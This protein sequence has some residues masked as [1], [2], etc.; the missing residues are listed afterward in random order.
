MRRRFPANKRVPHESHRRAHRIRE[1]HQRQKR[2]G[3]TSTKKHS[4]T[5]KLTHTNLSDPRI[6]PPGRNEAP[7]GP[8]AP[9]TRFPAAATRA[10][11]RHD[12]QIP[13]QNRSAHPN[14]Q[15][16]TASLFHFN[17]RSLSDH[18]TRIDPGN[19]RR[20]RPVSDYPWAD[21]HPLEFAFALRFGCL[22]NNKCW[23]I[24]NAYM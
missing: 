2:K 10:G 21:A 11:L 7:P 6:P 24:L 15:S 17:F 3:T 18:L 5:L 4:K 12:P 22:Y 19:R 9:R 1:E 13:G 14:C 8:G 16:R 23:F 20:T